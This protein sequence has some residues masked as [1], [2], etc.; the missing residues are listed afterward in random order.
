MQGSPVEVQSLNTLE[1]DWP[2]HD[3]PITSVISQQYSLATFA[4]QYF[5]SHK[6]K[7][8]QL[9]NIPEGNVLLWDQG[10]Q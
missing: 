10:V 2:Q 4:S 9:D 8:D 1:P 7:S 6:K 5:H 3:C